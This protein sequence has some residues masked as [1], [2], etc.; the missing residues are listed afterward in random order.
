MEGWAWQGM[1]VKI[2]RI[3]W[4]AGSAIIQSQGWPEFINLASNSF[5]TICSL[6][7]I[8][9]QNSPFS[10]HLFVACRKQLCQNKVSQNLLWRGT[11]E[12]NVWDNA[13]FP[14]GKWVTSQNK[15]GLDVT[16]PQIWAEKPR[17]LCLLDLTWASTTDTSFC[18]GR[19]RAWILDCGFWIE[20]YKSGQGKWKGMQISHHLLSRSKKPGI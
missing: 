5:W 17:I 18:R 8:K 11:S 10:P 15:P 6:K 20:I 3:T 2:W 12:K 13:T 14:Y 4:A 16:T 19:R 9:R 7:I 1:K